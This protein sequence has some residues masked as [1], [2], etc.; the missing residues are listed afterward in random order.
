MNLAISKVVCPFCFT[1]TLTELVDSA[2]ERVETE[3]GHDVVFKH[4]KEIV[5]LM[6]GDE[7]SH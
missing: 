6:K 3:D 2:F 5:E 4:A 1:E 7:T